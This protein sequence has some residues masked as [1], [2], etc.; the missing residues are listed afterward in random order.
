MKAVILAA[1]IGKRLKPI[2]ESIPKVM[3]EINSKPLLE[4]LIA[5][6]KASGLT[7]L[8]LVVGYKKEMIENYFK[9]GEKFG[10]KI[11]YVDQKEQ[12]GTGHAV[13]VTKD[14]TAKEFAVF[15]GDSIWTPSHIKEII[16]EFKEKGYDAAMSVKEA[17]KEELGRFGNVVVENSLVTNFIEKPSPDKAIGNLYFTGLLVFKHEIYDY[18]RRI[19]KS[20][21][22][23]Y[24]LPDAIKLMIKDGKRVGA[25]TADKVLDLTKQEDIVKLSKE[26]S[27]I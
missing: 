20:P 25:V 7:D 10:V 3:V 8:V 16:K 22:G 24:E 2:T 14:K 4:Y 1:G 17:R 27:H 11:E 6:L 9:N 26:I 5:V 21:R 15:Y 18:L 19:E 23:E 13:L 12:L